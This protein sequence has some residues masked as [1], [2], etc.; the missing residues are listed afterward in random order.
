[1]H[2]LVLFLSQQQIPSHLTS[3]SLHC[4]CCWFISL[5]S[6]YSHESNYTLN[7]RRFTFTKGQSP[8]CFILILPQSRIDHSHCPKPLETSSQPQNT[9]Q[10]LHMS[11]FFCTRCILSKMY[12]INVSVFSTFAI[13]GGEVETFCLGVSLTESLNRPYQIVTQNT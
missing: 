12:N 2:D 6:W 7:L 13:F 3:H 10:S 8:F 11:V 1:M 4:P 9:K 5:L